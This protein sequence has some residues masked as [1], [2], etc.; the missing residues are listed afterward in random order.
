MSNNLLYLV[1]R[2]PYP[3]N[4]GDKIRS[5]HLLQHLRTRY[6][7]YLGAFVDDE[8]DWQYADEVRQL[9]KESC[10]VPMNPRISKLRSLSGLLSGEALTLTY[11]RNA[12]L[13]SWVDTLIKD[14]NIDRIVVFSSAM[15][16][17]VEHFEHAQRIMDFVDVDSDKWTQYAQAKRWPLNTL[18]RREGKLLLD[19]EKKI[20]CEFDAS[21]FVSH[22][23][24]ALFRQLAPDSA[25]R[26]HSFNNGVDAKYFSPDPIYS[27]PYGQDEAVLVF[28][29]AMDYWPNIDAVEWFARDIFP[30]VLA[31][32]S[33]ACFYIVGSN[34]AKSV[35]RLG[36]LPG[37][38]VTGSVDD[39]RPYLAHA[40][41]AVAPLRIARG[42]QNKVL[43]AMAM[44]KPVIAT[45]QAMEGIATNMETG[46]F[47]GHSAQEITEQI[48]VQLNS[49]LTP[50][51][52]GRDTI[53]A[54]YDWKRNLAE[55]DDF[56][57]APIQM[58]REKVA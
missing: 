58:H 33:H 45:P 7:I 42:V 34:P 17:Y 12:Q 44:A 20:A 49:I 38:H 51:Q 47:T 56:L 31:K 11:Y 28:T 1:H 8:N 25:S 41:L 24:A 18:Y 35:V 3:P 26:I 40:R 4:K 30:Q 27:N 29:G 21:F 10:L 55:I 22:K 53:L 2:I 48:I 23:E 9:C 46:C 6:N 54:H 57:E 37:I 16:Q 50:N 19:Y 14:H 5:F 43:E 36:S 15:A 13:Q 32:K 39:V 52:A